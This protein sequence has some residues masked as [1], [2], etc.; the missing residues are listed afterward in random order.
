[1]PKTFLV[2]SWLYESLIISQRPFPE[3][4]FSPRQA[5]RPSQLWGCMQRSP[6]PCTSMCTC[7]AVEGGHACLAQSHMSSVRATEK[8]RK[9]S[10]GCS[11]SNV[12]AAA[13]STFTAC[14]SELLLFLYYYSERSCVFPSGLGMISEGFSRLLYILGRNSQYNLLVSRYSSLAD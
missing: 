11:Y 3:A 2:K 14:I 8:R 6:L 4:P 7:L 13:L 9:I 12:T 10:I 1:M 5:S